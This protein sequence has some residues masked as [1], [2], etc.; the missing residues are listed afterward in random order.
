[1]CNQG[2]KQ[3]LKKVFVPR[4]RIDNTIFGHVLH[5]SADVV[6]VGDR[7]QRVHL[8]WTPTI[9]YSLALAI[10]NTYERVAPCEYLVADCVPR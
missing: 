2:T 5:K 10:T 6:L 8:R 4:C 3:T 9:E 1:M 7:F